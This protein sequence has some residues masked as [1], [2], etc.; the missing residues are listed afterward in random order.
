MIKM[1][2]I[3]KYLELDAIECNNIEITNTN[4]ES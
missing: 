1:V 3:R 2:A 4:S